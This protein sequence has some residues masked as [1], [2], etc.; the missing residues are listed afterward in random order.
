MNRFNFDFL[1]DIVDQDLANHVIRGKSRRNLKY[2]TSTKG[3]ILQKGDVILRTIGEHDLVIDV[4]QPR[5]EVLKEGDRILRG[6]EEV[7]V[8]LKQK[9]LFPLQFGDLVE[10]QLR[11]GD[12]LLLNRQPTLHKASM[13]AQRCKIRVGN[14]IR[15]PLAITS[16]Y[17]ADFDGD[18]MNL[19]AP[20]KEAS[21]TEMSELSHQRHLLIGAQG[22][23]CNVKIVQDSLLGAFLMTRTKDVTLEKHQFWNICM[24]AVSERTF[25]HKGLSPLEILKKIRH[26]ERVYAKHGITGP[27]TSTESIAYTGRGIFSMILPIDFY[28]TCKNGANPDEPVVRIE[29]GVLLEGAINKKNLGGGHGSILRDLIKE[30]S[31]LVSLAFIDNVQFLTNAFLEVFGFT[32]GIEDCMATQEEE[33]A[34][35]ITRCMV[36]AQRVEETTTHP[37]IKEAKVNEAL[38]KARDVGMRLAK[39]ALSA[40]NNFVATVTAGSK[41]DYFNIAQIAGLL[42]QQNFSGGRIKSVLNRGRRSL[43]HE[44]FTNLTKEEE[45]EFKG[46][47]SGSFIRGLNP[48]ETYN[49]CCYRTRRC[50]GYCYE[51]C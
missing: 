4:L 29:E 35:A 51:N 49:H 12:M 26:I 42:G 28:Y 43:I 7:P 3:T 37:K 11:D 45:Y 32:V 38:S 30:Y 41:G 10:R 8:I 19:H 36:D 22:S 25:E 44:P 16:Q 33:I 39:D 47:V 14:T 1:Q 48:I 20:Q 6:D 17:N 27:K 31:Q 21:K 9:K 40:S 24:K 18:E 23:K 46:F 15:M 34:T 13:A 2:A 50:H 5:T